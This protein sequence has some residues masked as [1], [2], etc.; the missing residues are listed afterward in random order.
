MKILT[1]GNLNLAVADCG[2]GTPLVLVHGFPLDHSMWH[3][4]LDVL[5]AQYRVIAPDLRGFGRSGPVDGTASDA[6]TTMH[7]FADDLAAMLD[8][9]QIDEPVALAGLSMGGYIALAFQ[10][11]YADRLKALILMDTRS[12]ADAPEVAAS[13]L[14]TAETILAEGPGSLPG[15]MLPKLLS[16][17][18]QQEHPHVGEALGNVML[19]TSPQGIAAALRGMAQRHDATT[20]LRAITCPTLV[21]VGEE[22]AVSPPEEMQQ[23]AAAIPN[24]RLVVIPSAGHMSPAENPAAV[25]A[26]LLEFLGNL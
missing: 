14:T 8:A 2:Q 17:A 22:D 9:L 16:K 11:A 7:Q 1:L 21:V 19:R 15:N 10:K 20:Q 24:A 25:N 6:T 26:A 4:Q 3:A 12:S 18:T 13:R 23:I 5:S